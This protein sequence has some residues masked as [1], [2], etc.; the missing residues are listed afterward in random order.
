M[1]TRLES[2]DEIRA[3]LQARQA[4]LPIGA[5]PVDTFAAPPL[6]P[7]ATQPPAPPVAPVAHAPGSPAAVP[8]FKPSQRP[9][10]ALLH[11]FDDGADDGEIIR[12]RADRFVIGRADGDLVLP[13]DGQLS[14]RHAE[15]VRQRDEEGGWVWVLTDLGSTNGTFVRAGSAV[16]KDG[17]EFLVGRTR[18]RFDSGEGEPAAPARALAGAAGSQGSPSP[19]A[20]IAWN[21]NAGPLLMPSVVELT[22]AGP[23]GRTPLTKAEYW[24]GSDRSACAIVPADDP[25]VSPRHARLSK[26]AKGRWQVANNKSANGVWVR[27]EQMELAGSC[28][29]QLGEQRFSLKVP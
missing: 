22:P 2:V 12:L 6:P 4:G 8:L 28:Q 9:P 11:V 26:D 14:G 1:P 13:H 7:A 17:Q 16:L 27:V 20:T 21:S 23:G 3:A 10:T 15:L 25:F 5:A 29:F 19:K 24:I 18:Y